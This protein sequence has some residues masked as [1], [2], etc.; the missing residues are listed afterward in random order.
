MT[1]LIP[2]PIIKT[3]SE[4]VARSESHASLDNLFRY[5]GA[6][7]DPPEGSKFVKAQE[8][9]RIVNRSESVRPLDVLGRVIENYLETEAEEGWES[10]RRMLLRQA[11]DRHG[12]SYRRGK[13]LS[14]KVGPSSRNLAEIIRSRDIEA[15]NEEFT[16]AVESIGVDPREAV[17]AASNILE[18]VCKTYIEDEELRMPA[19]QDLP[20]VWTIVR[21][22]LNFDPS[23]VEEQDLQKILSG[24]ISVVDGI[25]ALR[26]HG[27]RAHGSG[28]RRYRLEER[29]ARLADGG[30]KRVACNQT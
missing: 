8:W 1:I 26:T 12:L 18:A 5:A 11:L 9:L 15:I 4:L 25:G 27:S 22:D 16:R 23:Q 29:H 30:D 3:V 19:K 7:G 10:E 20:S 14:T 17:S 21:K 28:R 13:V 6:P 2:G 24:M